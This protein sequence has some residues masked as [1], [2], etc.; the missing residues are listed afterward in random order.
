M[1]VRY[2]I[3]NVLFR[4][5][6]RI[7]G[8]NSSRGMVYI[9]FIYNLNHQSEFTFYKLM[10]WL[11]QSLDGESSS[12]ESPVP[13]IRSIGQFLLSRLFYSLT[14]SV[15]VFRFVFLCVGNGLVTGSSPFREVQHVCSIV[16]QK[17][18]KQ[19]GK[20]VTY[21]CLVW[22]FQMKIRT[23]DSC[24]QRLF[25]QLSILNCCLIYEP[26]PFWNTFCFRL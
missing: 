15:R 26:Q 22:Q 13:Q 21:Y 11:L 8:S 2:K 5:N 25:L 3:R 6:T 20:I 17:E 14:S 10:L 7:V 24:Y 4:F 16:R 23:L 12:G 18:K 19:Y 1:A 9:F